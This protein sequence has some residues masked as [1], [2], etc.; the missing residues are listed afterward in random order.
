[1]ARSR[2]LTDYYEGCKCNPILTHRHLGR[3]FPIVNV[4]HG[5]LVETPNGEW[6]MVLLASRPYGGRYRNLGR[7]TF[8]A[9]VS[10]EDEWPVVNYG[11]GLVREEEILPN[12]PT[13]EKIREQ[14]LN[15]RRLT[16]F[17]AKL[18]FL[19]N[20][21]REHYKL[22]NDGPRPGLSMQLSKNTLTQ[23]S[24]VSYLCVRQMH[25]NFAAS[26]KMHF[27]PENENEAAGIVIMQNSKFFY[28]F[29]V[30]KKDEKTIL[31][32]TKCENGEKKDLAI[33]LPLAEPEDPY[34]LE[35]SANGQELSFSYGAY[36]KNI[37]FENASAKFLNTDTAGGFVG[38]T[39][40]M[41][42]TSNGEDCDKHAVFTEFNYLAN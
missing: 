34:F 4:G 10:W 26:T 39:I 35:I 32:V 15:F 6:W 3:D 41:Y 11:I 23:P 30:T 40:G 42:A 12:L 7:E 37:V 28:E 13:Q 5:D 31:R 25:K 18:M 14:S 33:M 1:V 8:L 24:T 36:G 21:V 19:R 20:P 9:P 16:E 27:A 17:P 22:E 38:N 2:N 29:L